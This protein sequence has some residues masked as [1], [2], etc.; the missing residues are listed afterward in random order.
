MSVCSN[1]A[2]DGYVDNNEDTNDN[3]RDAREIKGL[4]KGKMKITYYNDDIERVQVFNINANSKIR[5]KQYK[6]QHYLALAPKGKKIALVNT[7]K[8]KV[9][10]KKRLSKDKKYSKNAIKIADLRN[11][12][13]NEAVVIS[14]DINDVRVVV[15]KIKPKKRRINKKDTLKLEL[16]KVKPSKTKVKKKLLYLK[17]K[18]GSKL[19]TLFINNKYHIVER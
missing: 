6:D 7:S 18:N 12:G 17:D 19:K 13:S 16:A 9:K 15:L 14:K 3:R 5:I 2:P 11:D 1:T 10:A 8:A 4:K